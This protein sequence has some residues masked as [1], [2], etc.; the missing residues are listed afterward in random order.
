MS[1]SKA[2]V[3]AEY[4]R[5][6]NSAKKDWLIKWK[7]HGANGALLSRRLVFL[8]DAILFSEERGTRISR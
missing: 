8:T 1:K 3:K 2:E 4:D 5:I 7:K 6:G